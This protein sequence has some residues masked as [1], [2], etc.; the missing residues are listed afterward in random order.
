MTL[1][2][3]FFVIF[4]YYY[5]SVKKNNSTY[6][7]KLLQ[8]LL[9]NPKTRYIT[10]TCLMD[11]SELGFENA[12]DI[13]K[14][15]S[16]LKDADFYKSMESKKKSGLWQDVYKKTISGQ[17]LYIKLQLNVTK[18]AVVISFKEDTSY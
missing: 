7:L 1:V 12:D 3:D 2:L 15:V 6:D 9:Q 13:V 14:A 5:L 18:Q 11:A 10:Y 17:K 4:I 8:D 16:N